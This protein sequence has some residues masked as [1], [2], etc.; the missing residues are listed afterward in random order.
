[1]GVLITKEMRDR[2]A[3]V[4]DES[5]EDTGTLNKRDI[6]TVMLENQK[7]YCK[8]AYG[9]TRLNESEASNSDFHQTNSNIEYQSPILVK[10]ARRMAMNLMAMDIMGVQPMR[11]PD[12]V[13][14]AM[15]AR[16]GNST[17]KEALH[18]DIDA[19]Y[20]GNGADLS[21]GDQHG[22][23]AG[24]V[25]AGDG[26][27]VRPEGMTSAD[28]EKLGVEGGK[29][30][31]KMG[32]SV[33]KFRAEAKSRALYASYTHELQQDMRAVHGED[34][35]TILADILV[36]EISAE[37][38]REFIR[39][40]QISAQLS[41]SQDPAAPGILDVSLLEGRWALER[42]KMM[43][44]I[45]EADSHDIAYETQRGK[46]NKIICSANFATALKLA[47]MLDDTPA[48]AA[49]ANF[50]VDTT[51]RNY[52]GKLATGHDVFVDPYATIQYYTVLYKGASQLDAFAF[53]MPY[54]PLEMFRANGEDSLSDSRLG[55][56][57]RYGIVANPFAQRLENGQMKVGEGL[58]QSENP[59]LRKSYVKNLL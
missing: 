53:F 48:L 24:H 51:G 36:T 41:T 59:Y 47:G 3:D 52:V 43:L 27:A 18:R 54:T 15:R 8:G 17:G 44:Y 28:A 23:P 56:K 5:A 55:F 22:F 13:G 34:V 29:V 6:A 49:Q 14:F 32:F 38:D 16:Y 2:W 40:A 33:E 12:T 46:G 9:G 42:W 57:S 58:G 45:L 20:S 21:T 11:A 31:A 26:D 50:T 10:M 4:L 19:S 1:M 37:M 25:D 7:E 39:T 30:W 35:D